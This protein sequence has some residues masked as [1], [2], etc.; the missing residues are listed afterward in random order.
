MYAERVRSGSVDWAAIVA[1]QSRA[2]GSGDGGAKGRDQEERGT[3]KHAPDADPGA[4]D[5]GAEPRTASRKAKEEG[6]VHRA[7]PPCQRRHA[8]GGILRA[9]TQSC[10]WGRRGELAGLRSEPRVQS[11][12][13]LPKSPPGS[14]SASSIAPDVHTEGGWSTTAAGN[15]GSGRQGRPGR[16]RHGAQR[17]LRGGFP[18][19]LVRVPT[20]TRA[21][22]C[23]GCFGGGDHPPEGEPYT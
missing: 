18:R 13:S 16:M 23:V 3:A 21:A 20:W 2:T 6:A 11:R 9:Q 12:G 15:R 17:H 4:R 5:P 10:R 14:V 7:S 1:E 19:V 22:R 8:L